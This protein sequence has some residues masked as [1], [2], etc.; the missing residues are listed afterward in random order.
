ML[1]G[2]MLITWIYWFLVVNKPKMIANYT[3]KY[4]HLEKYGTYGT[5][6]CTYLRKMCHAYEIHVK[7]ISTR[8]V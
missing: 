5:N 8:Y 1:L 4:S 3:D 7:N 6:N 2:A